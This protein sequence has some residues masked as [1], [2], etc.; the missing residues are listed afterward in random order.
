M[1]IKQLSLEHVGG[2]YHYRVHMPKLESCCNDFSGLKLHLDK[3]FREC[4]DDY[5]NVG[6]RSSRLKFSLPLEIKKINGHEVSSLAGEGLKLNKDRYKT[7]HSRIQV[8]FLERDDKTIA[9]EVPV[10]M[11]SWEL[12]NYKE[13][14]QSELPLTGHIDLVR[15][16]GGKIWVWDYKPRAAE[17]EFAGTQVYFY[18]L[19]LSARTGIPIENFRCGWFDNEDAFVFEPCLD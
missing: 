7:G 11:C 8:F 2:F 10:W 14:F 12:K 17:E 13:L 3:M 16:E 15:V 6:P 9:V 18:A 1:M 4:P 19:M 5:F